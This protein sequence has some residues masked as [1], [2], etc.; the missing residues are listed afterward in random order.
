MEQNPVALRRR[1]ALYR[2]YLRA[3]VVGSLAIRYLRQ[4]ADDDEA[5]SDILQPSGAVPASWHH[6]VGAAAA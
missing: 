1:I 2:S 6:P 5:L 4:I 3:G